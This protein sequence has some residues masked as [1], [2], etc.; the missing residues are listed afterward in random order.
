MSWREITPRK[1]GGNP[2]MSQSVAVRIEGQGFLR[3]SI[4]AGLLRRLA[5]ESL[6]RVCVLVGEGAD[7]GLLRL[8]PT[9]ASGY[10]ICRSGGAINPEKRLRSRVVSFS[11][12]GVARSPTALIKVPFRVIEIDTKPTDAPALPTSALEIELPRA[13]LLARPLPESEAA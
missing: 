1:G 13:L 7:A 6:D 4:R 5:W 8:E 2:K 11:C 3:I 10:K 12:E 9:F